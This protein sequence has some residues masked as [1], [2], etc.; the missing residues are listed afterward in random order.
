VP[1]GVATVEAT[2]PR[3]VSLG[4]NRDPRR[5]PG[6]IRRTFTVRDNV[7][8]AT[9]P[10]PGAFAFP[11]MVWRAADGSVIRRVPRR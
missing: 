9:V 3:V 6:T 2:F 11:R 5:F 1:D 8:L 10:R 7:V 4:P